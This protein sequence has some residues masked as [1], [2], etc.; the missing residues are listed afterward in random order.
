MHLKLFEKTKQILHGETAARCKGY[1]T[2]T[3]IAL[4]LSIYPMCVLLD[5]D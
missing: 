4:I 3:V 2:T 5:T 1:G